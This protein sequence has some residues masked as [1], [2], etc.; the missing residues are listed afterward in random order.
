MTLWQLRTRLAKFLNRRVNREIEPDE[1]FLDSANLPQFDTHQLEGRIERPIGKWSV[2]ALVFA[3]IAVSVGFGAKLYALQ[4]RDGGTYAALSESN[5]LRHSVVFA[6]RGVIYD[7]NRVE[8]AWNE[9]GEDFPLRRYAP[10]QGVAHIV[11]Y[12]GYPQK[13]ASGNYYRERY[14]GRSGAE[15]SFDAELTGVNGLRI[16]E[17]NAHNEE[18]SESA[19]KPPERGKNILLSIDSR[20]TSV[21]YEN[22][23][24]VAESVGFFGG[25]GIM[26]DVRTGEIIA[27]VSYPEFSLSTMVGG[28]DAAAVRRA[29]SDTRKPFLNRSV[30]GL[31]TP[32]SIVKP[33]I[34]S[35]ALEERVISPEKKILSTGA[36]SL[37]NPFD[38]E[39]PSIFKDWR[40]HGW[41][42][43]R[44]ALAVSSNV[45]FF[46]V[47]GGYEDQR[48]LGI[49]GIERYVR[50][51]G[52][53][54]RTGIDLPGEEIG[55]VPNPAWKREHFED[56]T[57]RIGDTYNTA[58]GQYGFQVTPVSVVRAVA[59]I[60]ND[61]ILLTP[62]IRLDGGTDVE[63]VPVAPEHLKVVREGMR[64]AVTEGTARALDLPSLAVAGKTGTAEL[65]YTKQFVNS[66]SIGFFPYERPAYAFVFLMEHGPVGNLTGASAVARSVFSWIVAHAPEYAE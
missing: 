34:A 58:I 59:A 1:I 22:I 44:H 14:E 16:V 54:E 3:F 62:T 30:A 49:A 56:G 19:L 52:I 7:R 10:T 23:A 21:F 12:L 36:L 37:P 32:G 15:K 38:P 33:F 61:G 4:V 5:R 55:A 28:E 17:T 53:G 35:G 64:L 50:A 48:G 29:L 46:E 63:R 51:F 26:M 66:W 24:R 31:Y 41:V 65:G 9:S 60:A 8:L 39:R 27:L 47:G 45:Y 2:W 6:E 57:W 25:T 40:A 20:L 42:D 11:G 18:Q 13:D 43:L